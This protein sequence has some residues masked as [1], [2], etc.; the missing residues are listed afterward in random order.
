MPTI[1]EI[2]KARE[3]GFKG[4]H[5][6]IWHVCIDCGKERWV[7]F[8]K[9]LP[10]SLKCLQCACAS[11]EHGMNISK[12]N[13]GNKN[14]NWKGGRKR[15]NRGYILIWLSPDDFFYPM[16]DI[17][18]YV[19]EHR[20]VVAKALGRNLHSW[21]IVHHTHAKYPAGSIE[22]K[23]DN[24]YPENLQLVSDIGHNQIT[25]LEKKIDKQSQLIEELR[26]EI[27]LLR[28]ENKQR[29]DIRI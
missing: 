25:I 8:R 23:Q 15:N 28:W 5:K 2:R 22:D 29:Q 1:E 4:N 7:Q 17:T 26:R 27:R 12:A 11:P 24:R 3:I 10:K 13:S 19:L 21:E 14:F 6:Y 20:L 9:G 16:A 18:G